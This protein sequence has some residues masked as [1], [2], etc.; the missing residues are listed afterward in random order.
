MRSEAADFSVSAV[1]SVSI[2]SHNLQRGE[3]ST[4]LR[5][6]SFNEGPPDRMQRIEEFIV[7]TGGR[8]SLFFFFF[9]AFSITFV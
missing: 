3:L 8:F 7:V 1:Y 5:R 6:G 2:S 4:D 9:G